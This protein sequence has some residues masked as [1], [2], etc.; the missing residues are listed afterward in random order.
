METIN[1]AQAHRWIGH[2][3]YEAGRYRVSCPGSWPNGTPGTI[4]YVR[5]KCTCGAERHE[6]VLYSWRPVTRGGNSA[7]SSA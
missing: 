1:L 2:N 4:E 5:Y 6:E 7:R 3:F